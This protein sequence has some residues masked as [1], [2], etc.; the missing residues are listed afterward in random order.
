MN[1]HFS[2]AEF[3]E[4]IRY[5]TSCMIG[6]DRLAIF[7]FSHPPGTLSIGVRNKL[8]SMGSQMSQK[9]TRSG[10]NAPI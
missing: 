8:V 4:D 5:S 6:C 3:V 10:L 7:P 9:A 1:N 2:S